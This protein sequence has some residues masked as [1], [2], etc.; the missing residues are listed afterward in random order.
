MHPLA[1][2]FAP[3]QYFDETLPGGRLREVLFVAALYALVFGGIVLGFFLLFGSTFTGLGN[4]ATVAGLFAAFGAVGAVLLAVT[5]LIGVPLVVGVAAVPVHVL[6]L[7]LGG[8]GSVRDTYVVTAWG[9]VPVLVGVVVAAGLALGA[10]ALGVTDGP[11]LPR[12]AGLGVGVVVLAWHAYVVGTGLAHAHEVSTAT[13]VG[14][15]AVLA[16]VGLLGGV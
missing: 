1:A 9:Q 12:V 6:V 11:T 13:G 14:S 10:A 5:F 4:G 2:A 8:S 15:A 3:D 16:L 7:A